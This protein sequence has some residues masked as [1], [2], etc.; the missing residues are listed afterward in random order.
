M[1]HSVKRSSLFLTELVLSLLVFI[2][3]AVVCVSLLVYSYNTSKNST[4]LT[5]AVFLAESMAENWKAYALS[6][7]GQPVLQCYDKNWQPSDEHNATYC[8]TLSQSGQE[9][10]VETANISVDK[11]EKSLFSLSVSRL[12]EGVLHE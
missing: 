6:A 12:K 9:G 7:D 3:C 5:H 4:N 11:G 1:K 10:Q 2:V 8:V